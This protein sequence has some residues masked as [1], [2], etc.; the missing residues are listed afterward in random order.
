MM[1]ENKL[2]VAIKSS[3]GK[4]LREVKDTIAV[5][6]GSEYSIYIKNLN[7][8]RV[9]VSITI[10][11]KSVFSN[12]VNLVV[13]PN[14]DIDIERWVTNNLK[15]NRFK[16]IERTSDIESFKGIGAEDGILRIA[17]KYEKI[18]PKIIP[19]LMPNNYFNYPTGVRTTGFIKASGSSVENINS[20]YVQGI[21]QGIT[22]QALSA[23]STVQGITVAGSVSDQKFTTISSF[24][25]E[26]TEHVIVLRL[27]GK[28]DG[29]RVTESITVKKKI[30]CPT[31]GVI[32]KSTSKFCSNCGTAISLL[33]V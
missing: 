30:Q 23:V 22:A 6:F 7:S 13:N 1:F 29:A 18:I 8:V 26:D 10:D 4:I 17:F 21:S 2:V 25:L 33:V 3:D 32:N 20:I 12:G 5:K 28:L 16:F 27:W 9:S 19:Q 31:C 24:P 14:T 11:G 15:G